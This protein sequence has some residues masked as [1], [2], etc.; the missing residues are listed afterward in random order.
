M[1]SYRRYEC[2]PS[3]PWPML[4]YTISLH[5]ASDYYVH[6]LLWPYVALTLVSFLVFFM[7]HEVGERLG[8]G[9]TLILA[10][11]VRHAPSTH[12]PPRA[13][14]SHGALLPCPWP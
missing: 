10:I 1:Q 12:R 8:F 5:R 3:E 4:L 2:C 11:E 14:H 7:S 6:L 13:T 9:I